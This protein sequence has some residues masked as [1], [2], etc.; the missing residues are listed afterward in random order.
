MKRERPRKPNRDEFLS[1][2]ARVIWMKGELTQLTTYISE[3]YG[4]RSPE[5]KCCWDATRKVTN[6]RWELENWYLRECPQQEREHD[7][8]WGGNADTYVYVFDEHEV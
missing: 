8:F 2:G 4:K 6:L 7:V 5:A 3:R 1:I